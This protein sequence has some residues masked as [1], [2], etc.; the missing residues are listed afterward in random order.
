[1]SHL[2]RKRS[3]KH[4]FTQTTQVNS[5]HCHPIH[6]YTICHSIGDVQGVS[7]KRGP[8]LTL[9]SFLYFPRNLSKILCGHSKMILLCSGEDSIHS[10][11]STGSH[12]IMTS[13][14]IYDIILFFIRTVENTNGIK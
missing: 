13:D 14:C 5:D 8:F 6:V 10:S 12:V 7:E 2:I 3:F 9:V 11:T 1:M 4:V